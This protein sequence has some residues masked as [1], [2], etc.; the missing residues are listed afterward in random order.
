VIALRGFA[1]SNA[2][3]ILV[4]TI[5]SF[6][7]DS[8]E[9]NGNGANGGNG[10]GNGKGGKK[11]KKSKGNVIN[12]V[13]E[14]GLRH[15]EFIQATNP[16]VI[17][18]EP[19]NFETD[20]RKQAL[21]R[22]N[23]LC[24]LRYSAT[25]RNAYN[26]VYQLDPIRALREGRVKQIGV[27]S[28]TDGA[29]ANQSYVEL[30]GFRPGKRSVSARVK[31]WVNTPSGPVKKVVALK[32]GDDLHTLS[33]GR[34]MYKS[35]YIV[36]EIDAG[37]QL[38][39]FANDVTVRS[40]QPHGSLTETIL[41][42]QI[43]ATVRR[44]FEKEA[45]LKPLGIKVLSVLF[46]DRV[47]NYRKYAEDGSPIKGKFA[48]WFEEIFESYRAQPEYSGLYPFDAAQAHN[49]YFSQDKQGH[50]KD[51]KGKPGR[52]RHLCPDHEQEG[53]VA[54]PRRAPAIHL[55]PFRLA[56]GMG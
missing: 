53:G 10:N 51:R 34:E 39:R 26:L 16:I 43:D 30:A 6:S 38:V 44:H 41:R 55:Q 21:A 54:R 27:D 25:P 8:S 11:R 45:R 31:I 33:G 14:T 48:L 42:L 28:V 7:K 15:I 24:T 13:R 52:Q 3:E 50:F 29:N 22:L 47:A 40:G 2:I 1:L 32:N 9:Q 5:D 56:R 36:N 12:Q 46:I 37:E 17:V 23:P 4:I 35:G 20:I 49:G 19:Q 18:D